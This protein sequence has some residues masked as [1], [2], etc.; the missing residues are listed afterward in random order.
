VHALHDGGDA[1]EAHAG[2]HRGLGQRRLL[3]VG[4]RSNCMNTRFQIST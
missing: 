1:L 3:A 4:E 2:I